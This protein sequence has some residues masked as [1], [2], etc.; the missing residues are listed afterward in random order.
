MI[1]IIGAIYVLGFVIFLGF[2]PRQFK[3]I[4]IPILWPL[5]AIWLVYALTKEY[6]YNRKNRWHMR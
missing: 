6:L 2:E 3:D 1:S 5:V 4:L